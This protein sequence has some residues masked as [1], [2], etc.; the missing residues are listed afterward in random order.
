M[1]LLIADEVTPSASAAALWLTYSTVSPVSMFFTDTA[2]ELAAL[3][4]ATFL[5]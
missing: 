2:L 3:P 5:K 4:L 1:Q